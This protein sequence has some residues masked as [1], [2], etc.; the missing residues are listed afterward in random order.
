LSDTA[1]KLKANR[2]SNALYFALKGVL[3]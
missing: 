3:V 2:G 1:K